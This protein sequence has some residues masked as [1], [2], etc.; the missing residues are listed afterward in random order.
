[1]A[2][3]INDQYRLRQQN[4]LDDRVGVAIDV[5]AL[6][7]WN[8]SEVPIPEG[9]EVFVEGVWYEY[10][11]EYEEDPILGKFRTRTNELG[12]D[13]LRERVSI[14]E[15]KVEW[16]EFED[17]S[18]TAPTLTTILTPAFWT[19]SEG[20]NHA[21]P[22][23]I[24]TITDDGVNNGPW[25]LTNE[26][27][28]NPNS[29]VKLIG[30]DDLI[31]STSTVEPTDNKIYSALAIDL[32][33]PKKAGQEE[34][35]GNWTF[36]EDQIFEKDLTAHHIIVEKADIDD[37]EAGEAKITDLE[38][39][40]HGSIKDEDGQTVA[41]VDKIISETSD[42]GDLDQHIREQMGF[43][44]VGN[45]LKN[46][47]FNG[48]ADSI[49]MDDETRLGD[50][51]E[52]YNPLFEDWIITPE[53]DIVEDEDSI[54]G[55][56]LYLVANTSI[57]TQQTVVNLKKDS[58]YI[59][60]WKQKGEILAYINDTE[61]DVQ[62]IS[63]TTNY[64]F[65]YARYKAQEDGKVTVMFTGG[66]GYI[67]EIKL[68][69]GTLP[70]TWFPSPL[71]TDPIANLINSY[72]YLKTAFIEYPQGDTTVSSLYLKNQ[73][74]V[75]EVI[76]DVVDT[77]FG[78]LSGI[79]S[80]EKDIMLWS[81]GTY[82]KARVLLSRVINDE[83]YLDRLSQSE[84]ASLAKAII[85][86]DYKTIFTDIYAVGKFKGQH[87]DET[88]DELCAFNRI[89]GVLPASGGTKV[90]FRNGMLDE[91]HYSTFPT[92]IQFDGV[93]INFNS[94]LCTT[95]EGQ[96]TIGTG[97]TI[98]GISSLHLIFH[99]GFL[100]RVSSVKDYNTNYYWY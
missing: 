40:S 76:N 39:G 23:R 78:G 24:V 96:Y 12:V 36:K 65:C 59:L 11:S 89:T 63:E 15:P 13:E 4:F 97:S 56:S 34:I 8:F 47:A 50:R 44:G 84:L 30:K 2:I 58:V 86:F 41:R 90:Y 26:V 60:S 25:Y 3:I 93:K 45:I 69:Q 38:V 42:I 1:M 57:L 20:V 61:L 66:P 82:E 16:L 100:V 80:D 87:L 17:S 33:F 85:T 68:E 6:K 35:T 9:F 22:G 52:L 7:S 98:S 28:T 37:L 91:N 54:T 95:P 99:K 72:E 55:R 21:R 10:K 49:E 32:K 70:T 43:V 94:G 71:D 83:T 62:I 77:H 31:H 64:K 29:W 18:Y 48:Q 14:L 73:I 46:T 92:S 51:T 79:I 53:W 81:G 5:S 67:F 75:G 88:G 27:Y 74:R 19:D